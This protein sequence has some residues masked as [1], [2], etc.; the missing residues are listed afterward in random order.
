MIPASWFMQKYGRKSGFLLGT[1]CGAAAGVVA[2]LALKSRSFELF[3]LAGMLMGCYQC[4]AHY[5]RFAAADLAKQREKGQAIAWVIGGGIVAAIA[6]PNIARYTQAIGKVP[7]EATYLVLMLLG[8][9]AAW[10]VTGLEM[11]PVNVVEGHGQGRSL[12]ALIRMPE[13]FIALIG[14]AI[15]YSAMMAIMTA[16]PLA[17]QGCG[18]ALGAAA[19]TIQWHVLGMYIPSF[20]AGDLVKRFG[21]L[22]IM[23]MGT[24]LMLL[25]VLVSLSGTSLPHFVSGLILL[26]IGW[27]FLFV[28]STTLLTEVYMPS[29]RAKMQGLSNFMIF[30]PTS[31]A[32]FSSGSLIHAF[33]WEALNKVVF[34]FLAMNLLM[35]GMLVF[36]RQRRTVAEAF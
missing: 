12:T 23:G 8:L 16:T 15:A 17:M 6:G 24:L 14:S 20:F 28:G 5:Y 36:V 7:F 27:N 9:L 32:S 18:Q 10:V 26:G 25:Q 34:I 33:G 3:V 22:R 2:I 4:L 19:T 1:L 31:I 35:I 21:S 13:V 11:P 30:V 29:E